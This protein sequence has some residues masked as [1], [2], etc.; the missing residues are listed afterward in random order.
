M[1]FGDAFHFSKTAAEER[2]F[3]VTN[4][5]ICRAQTS[6]A[7]LRKGGPLLLLPLARNIYQYL[8]SSLGEELIRSNTIATE[9]RGISGCI[10]RPERES[11]KDDV[12]IAAPLTRYVFPLSD[13]D[14]RNRIIEIADEDGASLLYYFS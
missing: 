13:C 14:K 5:L 9:R 2:Y 6:I 7:F 3:V 10:S 8:D 1:C 4:V 12:A 11:D